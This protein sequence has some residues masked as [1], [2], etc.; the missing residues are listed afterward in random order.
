[1]AKDI[2]IGEM[3]G[4]VKEWNINGYDVTLGVKR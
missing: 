3:D 4:Y 2:V 1:M